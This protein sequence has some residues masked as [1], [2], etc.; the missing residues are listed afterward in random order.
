V[1]L[2]RITREEYADDLTSAGAKK[3]GGRWNRPGLAALYTSEARSLALLELLV[4]FNSISALRQNYVFITFEIEKEEIITVEDIELPVNLISFNNERLWQITDDY[5]LEKNTLALRVPSVIIP[6]EYNVIL[7]PNHP[8]LKNV[9]RIRQESA[10]LDKR[11][12]R[13]L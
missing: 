9:R 1:E 3:Y 7:N 10:I 8:D 6:M 2:F 13:S 11:L 5:F 4:H 12:F